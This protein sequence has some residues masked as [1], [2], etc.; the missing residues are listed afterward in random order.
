VEGYGKH[1]TR[2]RGQDLH[3]VKLEQ[4]LLLLTDGQARRTRKLTWKK[5]TSR[6]LDTR[7]RMFTTRVSIFTNYQNASWCL[8]VTFTEVVKSASSPLRNNGVPLT[9]TPDISNPVISNVRPGPEHLLQY[10]MYKA[11]LPKIFQTSDTSKTPLT[12]TKSRSWRKLCETRCIKLTFHCFVS[13]A[14]KDAFNNLLTIYVQFEILMSV[15]KV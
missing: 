5:A 13:R 9:R 1:K 14:R 15:S 12:R 6:N 8:A 2:P 10:N 3:E 4:S 7:V 11:I